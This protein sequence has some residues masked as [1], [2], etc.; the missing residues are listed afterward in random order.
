MRIK[1]FKVSKFEDKMNKHH[2]DNNDKEQAQAYTI[3]CSEMWKQ[4]L[5]QQLGPGYDGYAFWKCKET[6][7]IAYLMS[8]HTRVIFQMEPLL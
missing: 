2:H 3:G 7:P 5:S 6:S 4:P 8:F 1:D